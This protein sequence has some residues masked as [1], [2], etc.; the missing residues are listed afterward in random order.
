MTWLSQDEK[1]D[2]MPAAPCTVK[3][4]AEGTTARKA[5]RGFHIVN[6]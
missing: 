6:P 3:T 2:E 5:L 4:V 1:T